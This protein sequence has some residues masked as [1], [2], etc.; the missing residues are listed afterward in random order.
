MDRQTDTH[1]SSMACIQPIDISSEHKINQSTIEPLIIITPTK[2][3][4]PDWN[5]L[6]NLEK[7]KNIGYTEEV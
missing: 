2:N 5:R 1:Y 4:R 7:E 6:F 3:T